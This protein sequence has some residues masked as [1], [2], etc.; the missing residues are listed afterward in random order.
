MEK[1]RYIDYMTRRFV[2]TIMLLVALCESAKAQWDVQFSDY[3]ALKSYYNPGVSGTEGKLNVNAAYSMQFLG[4]DNAPATMYLAGDLPVYFMSPRHGAGVSLTSDQIGMFRTM[5]IAISYAYN[6]KIGKK[7]RLAIGVRPS[8]LNETIDPSDLELEDKTSDPAFP[9]SKVDGKH[10]DFAAGIY[11]YHPKFWAGLSSLHLLAPTLVMSEKYE[12]SVP[13]SYYFMAGCN[14]RLKNTLVSLQP[15]CM[16]MTD[17]ASIREDV[18]CKVA[19]EFE[20]RKMYVGVGYSP[21]VSTTFMIGGNFHGVSLGYSY[22]M[23]TS[24]VN[25]INGTH[26]IVLGYQTD[27]DLFKKG[28]NLHKSVRWL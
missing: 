14:I 1:L 4:Y 3:T 9:S 19:Y 25:M 22:Q 6:L 13:R 8:L 23:Y 24:G 5:D 12:V 21:K 17:F 16:V 18:Q 26:E 15:S 20:S 10:V 28:R 7:G 2:V 11:F 27:L